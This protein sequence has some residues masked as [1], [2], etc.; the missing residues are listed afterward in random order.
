[1]ASVEHEGVGPGRIDML[2]GVADYSGSLV[3]QVATRVCTTALASVEAA[4]AAAAAAAGEDGAA[5]F[6]SEG[7]GA[8]VRVSL[9][10]L[11][12]ALAAPGGHAALELAGVRAF[13][14][15]MQPEPAPGWVRYM[16]GSLAAFVKATGWLPP[17]GAL[18]RLRVR[19]SVPASQGVSSSASIEIATLRALEGAA[20]IELGKLRSA[21]MAQSAENFVVGAPCGLMDQL[22]SAL[23]APGRVLPILCRPDGVRDLVPLP[24]AVCL[25]GWPSGVKHSVAA[26]PYLVARTA[27]FMGRAIVE[28]L[29]A[30]KDARD[31]AAAA[32]AGGAAAAPTTSAPRRALAH[33]A[34]L[35]PSDLAVVL[36]DVPERM[37]GAAFLAEFGGV[38]DALSVID[39]AHEYLVRASAR[40]PVEESFRCALALALLQ[41]LP[42]LAP[43][44]AAYVD[45]LSH[46]GELMR[47]SHRGY[48]SI[49]LGCHETDVML[50]RLAAL[51]PARGIYGARMSG[52]GSGGTVAVLLERS[53]LPQLEALAREL[54]FGAPF[55]GL[56][57]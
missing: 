50:E 51:G 30:A 5:L 9:A 57:F 15:A 14:A 47:Q 52:G 54:T 40:F 44:G 7:F 38:A 6:E 23:G 1:M 34:E 53:A 4:A 36:D 32:A 49:G 11:R 26:S 22:A 24:D 31:A 42:S 29:L 55:T 56:I 3:L 19:S 20:G 46:I 12:A 2:G 17:P 28:R 10:P 37:T 45:A 41:T 39:P 16:Y 18:L 35:T 25:V 48:G 13:L 43:G 33:I 21:H 27:T 8:G